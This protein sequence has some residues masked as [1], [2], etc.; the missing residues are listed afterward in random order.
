MEWNEIKRAIFR[1]L[2]QLIAEPKLI[3]RTLIAK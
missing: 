3:V 1:F 2:V